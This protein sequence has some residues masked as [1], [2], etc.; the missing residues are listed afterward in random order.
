MV[1]TDVTSWVESQL[2]PGLQS[3]FMA[4]ID[5][6]H[7]DGRKLVLAKR[8]L[9]KEILGGLDG[10][11]DADEGDDAKVWWVVEPAPAAD[12]DDD[13]AENLA[14]AFTGL[15]LV[16]IVAPLDTSAASLGLDPPEVTVSCWQRDENRDGYVLRVGNKTED[17]RSYYVVAG[18]SRYVFAVPGYA[19]SAVFDDPADFKAA[20]PEDDKED[21]AGDPDGD[22]G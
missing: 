10:V 12:A 17:G 8:G 6:A 19:L 18:D 3:D 15:R 22:G 4:R 16:D 9:S 7:A 5:V 13:K 14:R 21:A 2:W 11:P 20:P 1:S